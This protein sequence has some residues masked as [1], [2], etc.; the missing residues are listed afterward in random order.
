MAV[1]E[2]LVAA[3]TV[4]AEDAEEAHDG[5]ADL[6]ASTAEVTLAATIKYVA[7][8]KCLGV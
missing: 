3:E 2:S 7:P 4:D 1:V 8:S 5:E 6:V